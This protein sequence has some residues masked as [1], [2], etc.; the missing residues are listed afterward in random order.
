[1]AL[2]PKDVVLKEEIYALEELKG[3]QDQLLNLHEALWVSP[4]EGEDIERLTGIT[5][6]AE[7]DLEIC[8]RVAAK[9]VQGA[10]SESPIFVRRSLNP[11]EL[12]RELPPS[13]PSPLGDDCPS[14]KRSASDG[15]VPFRP[16]APAHHPC[17]LFRQQVCPP[18][19]AA[20]R[21]GCLVFC[22][23][24]LSPPRGL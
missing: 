15:S 23:F 11:S 7:D 8:Q 16:K 3:A 10:N 1:M 13:P 14:L 5:A 20:S 18:Q 4:V 2:P 24:S 12:P 21:T 22:W 17:N 19:D 6:A 9:I